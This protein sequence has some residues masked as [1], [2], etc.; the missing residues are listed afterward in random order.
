MPPNYPNQ[1]LAGAARADIT[2]PVDCLLG[3]FAGRDHG[4]EGLHDNLSVTAL[5]LTRQGKRAVIIGMD[6]LK[7]SNEQV[8]RIWKGA[9]ERCGLKPG[10]LFINCSHTHAGPI[11]TPPFNRKFCPE[12]EECPPDADYI[13]R[14][15]ETTALTVERAFENQKTASADWAAGK[16]YIGINRRAQ[17]ISIYSEQ[18]TGYENFPNPDKETDRSC[19][20]MLVSGDDRQ[21]IA[22]LFGASCHPTTMRYNNYLIS[23]EFPGVARRILEK[24][25]N[26]APS[27]FL[28]GT[29]G[30]VKP[31]QVAIENGFRNGNFDD[32]EAVGT[33]LADD[34]QKT[35]ENGLTPL[36]LNIK[37]AVKRFAIPF[38]DGWTEETYRRYAGENEP[39]YRRVWARYWLKQIAKG[40]PIPKSLDLTLSILELTPGVRF[41]GVAGELLTDMA[42]KIKHHFADGESLLF[43]YTNGEIAYIPDAAVLREGGYEATETIFFS[44]HMPAPWHEDIEKIILDGFDELQGKLE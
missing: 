10:E 41:L 9:N 44:Q 37:Y 38:A 20:V 16:T 14:L 40:A 39:E 29:A 7:L 17:D 28:Q 18:A 11:M 1:L 34:V 19:P 32:V 30:D 15:I 36:E 25:L 3:G 24:N 6:I 12:N 8:D 35:I 5:A 23:A 2:P 43:G 33:E 21:P 26:G 13:D 27:L 42:L 31:R 4:C 22:L